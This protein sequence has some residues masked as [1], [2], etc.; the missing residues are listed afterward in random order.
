MSKLVLPLLSLTVFDE[1]TRSGPGKA[2]LESAPFAISKLRLAEVCYRTVKMAAHNRV[3]VL[4]WNTFI[5]TLSAALNAHIRC[6]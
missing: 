6:H 4:Q 2:G 1:G 3:I 5:C